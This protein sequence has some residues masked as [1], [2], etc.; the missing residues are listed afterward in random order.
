MLN[1]KQAKKAARVLFKDGEAV[2]V[3]A[4]CVIGYRNEKQEVVP[5]GKGST[6]DEAVGMA[7]GRIEEHLRNDRE[8]KAKVAEAVEGKFGDAESEKAVLDMKP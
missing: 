7:R 4:M 8:E 2:L 3:P 6:W 1:Y 5:V